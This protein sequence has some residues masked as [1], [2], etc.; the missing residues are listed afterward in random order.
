MSGTRNLAVQ[1]PAACSAGAPG[2]AASDH[3]ILMSNEVK[4][5]RLRD[6]YAAV[7]IAIVTHD[8]RRD[9]SSDACTREKL[10]VEVPPSSVFC[11]SF[12]IPGRRMSVFPAVIFSKK[13]D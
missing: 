13:I 5:T 7:A 1:A 10:Q 3:Q 4:F 2:Q 6:A 11:E 12:K 9:V 8:V